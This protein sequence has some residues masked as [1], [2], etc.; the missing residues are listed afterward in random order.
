MKRFAFSLVLVLL[1]AV[2]AWGVPASNQYVTRLMSDGS[3][4]RVRLS[5]D[6]FF[7]YM[8]TEDGRV[9]KDQDGLMVE[10]G[11]KEQDMSGHRLCGSYGVVCADLPA[12]G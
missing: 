6:E 4:V 12:W 10:T 8:V 2:V 7:S 1:G 5:G 11:M 3:T 9:V